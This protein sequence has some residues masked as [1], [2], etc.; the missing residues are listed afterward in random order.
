MN[1][2]ERRI[3]LIQEL[4]KE[5]KRYEDMEIPQDFEEQRELLRA[6]MNVRIAKNVDDEFIKVQ[7]E[8]LK[9]EIKRKGIV[10]IDDLKPI[11]DGIYLW[12]GDIT[13]LRCDVIVNAA[14]SGMT[15]CYVPNQRCI[16]NC[17]HSFAGVQLRLECD[18]I[19]TKQGYS[20]PTGQAKITNSYNLPCKYIIHTVGPIING[21]LTS[22]DCDLLE[23][24]YK[25]CLE[26]AAKNNLDSIAFCCISTGE[27][28]FPNDKAAQIAVKTVEEFMKKETSLKKV[29]FNVFKD[30]D[31]EIYRKLLK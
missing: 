28:H 18:E 20:E 14:N 23:S 11:K 7:D 27:F 29:I 25:S 9:E 19:M 13:T 12:Q 1:Q 6:L 30:M 4:L 8:Y 2:N 24:C 16:D 21:K 26:L 5:N 3:F 22:E 15:G 31:K 10:D 17:I